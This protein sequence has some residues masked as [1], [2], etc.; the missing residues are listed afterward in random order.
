MPVSGRG[1]ET[2]GLTCS[3]MPWLLLCCSRA[4]LARQCTPTTAAASP[5][6]ACAGGCVVGVQ[7]QQLSR[8]PV[9]QPDGTNRAPSRLGRSV[10]RH[11]LRAGH[12]EQGERG[13]PRKTPDRSWNMRVWDQS[14]SPQPGRCCAAES[15][16]NAGAVQALTPAATGRPA[17]GPTCRRP[18]RSPGR[19]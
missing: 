14:P 10:G 12:V 3:W 4:A 19:R 13:L 18:S 8:P 5:V 9:R 2:A 17:P 6:S 15:P 16:N 7:V 11:G 1:P